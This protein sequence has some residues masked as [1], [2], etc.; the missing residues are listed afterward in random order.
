MDEF[1]AKMQQAIDTRFTREATRCPSLKEMGD[2]I[3]ERLGYKVRIEKGECNTDRKAGRLRIPGKGRIGN[4]LIV[5]HKGQVLLDH[6]SAETYRH[7]T[8]V[9]KW[10]IEQL[11]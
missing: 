6:N 10:I 3:N 9:A 1:Q 11:T 8:E 4:R 2:F 5:T 7:N